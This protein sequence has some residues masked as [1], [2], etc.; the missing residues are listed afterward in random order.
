MG[1]LTFLNQLTNTFFQI[2]S[3]GSRGSVYCLN[4][5]LVLSLLFVLFLGKSP[6]R[7]SQPSLWDRQVVEGFLAAAAEVLQG[8]ARTLS[9]ATPY[10][11]ARGETRDRHLQDEDGQEGYLEEKVDAAML[12]V[13]PSSVFFGSLEP[14]NA[15]LKSPREN[16]PSSKSPR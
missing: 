16:I 5:I 12:Q 6:L 14:R 4:D 15:R 3:E 7:C 13:R 10:K 2:S 8:H 1:K 9:G 11:P